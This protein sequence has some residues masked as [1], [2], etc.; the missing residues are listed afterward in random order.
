MCVVR[1]LIKISIVVVTT[2]KSYA[3]LHLL[4][5]PNKKKLQQ[6]CLRKQQ[7]MHIAFHFTSRYGF[8]KLA[9]PCHFIKKAVR[10][11]YRQEFFEVDVLISR[12]EKMNQSVSF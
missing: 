7:N 9:L 5:N 4:A 1:L 11:L 12:T 2:T 6:I 10:Q 8:L 3:N